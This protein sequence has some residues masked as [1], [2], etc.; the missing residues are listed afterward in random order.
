[1]QS[2]RRARLLARLVLAWF[3]LAIGVAIA[4]PLVHP[5]A[6]QRICSPAGAVKFV[7]QG[8]DGTV[9]AVAAHLDCPLCLHAGAAPPLQLAVRAPRVAP[10]ERLTEPI[11][12]SCAVRMALAPLPA[13]G[14]PSR[15]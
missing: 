13:R 1:M 5:Q 4:S 15:I 6:L 8:D 10:M 12:A 9:P 11:P 14:P 7:V 2:L 3:G